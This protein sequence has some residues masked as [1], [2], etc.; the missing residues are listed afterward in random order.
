MQVDELGAAGSGRA[1]GHGNGCGAEAPPPAAASKPPPTGEI[2]CAVPAAAA[3]T[4]S[5]RN[6]PESASAARNVRRSSSFPAPPNSHEPD[7]SSDA[8]QSRH[9]TMLV[10]SSAWWCWR[11][12]CGF[13]RPARRFQGLP[14]IPMPRKCWS[15]SLFGVKC[16]GCGLTRSVVYLAHGDWRASL[17]MHRLGIVMAAAILAQ[18]P[19]VPWACLWKK[20]TRWAVVSRPS[21]PGG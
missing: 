18:F 5:R 1:A 7:S 19:I 14:G 11:C 21:L 17:A 15:R 9:R 8:R 16:P 3:N 2:C 20:D 6:T 10:V 12:C 13:E 4:D